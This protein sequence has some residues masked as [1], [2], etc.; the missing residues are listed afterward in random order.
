MWVV[1]VVLPDGRERGGGFGEKKRPAQGKGG[2]R[3]SVGK[4][5]VGAPRSFS[6]MATPPMNMK[7]ALLVRLVLLPCTRE[8]RGSGW[9]GG[10]GWRGW[11]ERRARELHQREGD[12]VII[13]KR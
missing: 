3:V 6:A 2:E 13:A 11:Y 5:A 12:G 10:R 1:P 8:E 4:K 7:E 9:E